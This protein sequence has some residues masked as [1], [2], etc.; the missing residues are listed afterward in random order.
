MGIGASLLLI[1]IGA[2]LDFG[3]TVRDTHGF[4]I[5]DIGMI[6]IIVG[7]VGILLSLIFW[8]SWGGFGGRRRTIVERDAMGTRGVVQEERF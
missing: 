2:V 5:H 4:N 7:A 3:I 1:A 8:G 6:L